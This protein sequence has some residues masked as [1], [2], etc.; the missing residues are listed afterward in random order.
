M[1]FEYHTE[2]YCIVTG[3]RRELQTKVIHTEKRGIFPLFLNERFDKVETQN[4]ATRAPALGTTREFVSVYVNV[5]VMLPVTKSI[6]SALYNGT[7]WSSLSA[8]DT[9]DDMPGSIAAGQRELD[10]HLI[11]VQGTVGTVITER[12]AAVI[13]LSSDALHHFDETFLHGLAVVTDTI[14]TEAFLVPGAIAQASVNI[15]R[16]YFTSMSHKAAGAAAGPHNA[17]LK[18]GR[19]THPSS[20]TRTHVF[21][22]VYDG[23]SWS[24]PYVKSVYDSL[25]AKGQEQVMHYS[26][27]ST[28]SDESLLKGEKVTQ[29]MRWKS[30]ATSAVMS[31]TE[32]LPSAD[33]PVKWSGAYWL[34][35]KT[36]AELH[37]IPTI[38]HSSTTSTASSATGTAAV[39]WILLN[40][41]CVAS[42][43]GSTWQTRSPNDLLPL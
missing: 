6:S 26:K 8:G 14:L 15:A 11:P 28:T 1:L 24:D 29:H 25:V 16:D 12:D 41:R 7:T 19:T 21:H 34:E 18:N 42:L 20:K 35:S 5:P 40:D 9:I 43:N 36:T 38:D 33:R 22:S 30:T 32:C 31:V 2:P 37:D 39:N 17:S 4:W 23:H 10:T 13:D 27:K 3:V